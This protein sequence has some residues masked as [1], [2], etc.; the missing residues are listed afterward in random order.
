MSLIS[1]GLFFVGCSSVG[2]SQS[3]KKDVQ[4]TTSSE[5]LEQMWKLARIGDEAISKELRRV[6]VL[7]FNLKENRVFGNNGCNNYFGEIKTL[8]EGKLN[9]GTL[10][11]TRMACPDSDIE[12]KYM[13]QLQSVAEFYVSSDSLYLLD[14]EAKTLLCFERIH[15][16]NSEEKTNSDKPHAQLTNRWVASSI[17]GK[18]VHLDTD[19]VPYINI[20]I[21]EQKISGSDGCNLLMGPLRELTSDSIIIGDLAGTLRMCPDNMEIPDLFRTALGLVKTYFI[22]GN[23]LILKDADGKEVIRLE[24]GIEV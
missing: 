12:F 17:L 13:K 10:G 14:K 6:P 1:A 2:S 9:L 21:E 11:S 3:C 5:A 19:Q 4:T 20:N 24:S 23:T 15:P 22:E 7:E 16:D 8:E 18:I